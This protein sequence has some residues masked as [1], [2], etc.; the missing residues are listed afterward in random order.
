LARLKLGRRDDPDQVR[1]RAVQSDALT[2]RLQIANPRERLLVRV[3]DAVTAPLAWRRVPT[4]AR[5]RRVLLLRLERIGDLLMALDAIADVRQAWPDAAVDLAVGS[6]NADLAR[7]IPGVTRVHTADLPWLSRG[8]QPTSWP[9][10]LASAGAW[11]R[12][13]YDVVINFEPDI[14]TNFLAWRTAARTRAG[15]WTGGGG[16]FLT[17][18]LAYDPR[19]HVAWNARRL[20]ADV[21]GAAMPASP[22]TGPRLR[23]PPD[24]LAAASAR[25]TGLARPWIGVHPSGGRQS[26]QWHLDRFALTAR[27][28]ASETGGSIVVTGGPADGAE[29]AA[30]ERALAG[31]AHRSVAGAT[32][33][34]D[35]VA[36]VAALDLLVTGDTGP[37]HIAGAV[38]TPVVALF[39]PSEPARYGPR[40]TRERIVRVDL[41]CSPCGQVRLPPARCRGHV[42]D[43]MDGI[44]VDAVVAAAMDLLADL[45]PAGRSALG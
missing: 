40:A 12:S 35:V 23:V 1:D 15:Y 37:M 36:L 42:P 32:S 20:V 13:A 30:V 2:T 43:C 8:E 5:P 21:T 3:A 16:A 33:L 17:S 31:V 18:R 11:R 10:L 41:P 9:A 22:S 34:P 28:L 14:R 44:S 25:L 6:W 7:M 29:V 27:R 45:R 38:D 39:G 24:A 19:Q 4:P 26:K